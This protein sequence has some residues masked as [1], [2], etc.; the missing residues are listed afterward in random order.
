MHH[1]YLLFRI[2]AR[3]NLIYLINI[4]NQV[5]LVR[6]QFVYRNGLGLGDQFCF[7]L[8]RLIFRLHRRRRRLLGYRLQGAR[9][10][11]QRLERCE[12]LL[13]EIV[14]DEVENFI[15]PQVHVFADEMLLSGSMWR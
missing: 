3:D 1:K 11:G 10:L 6:Q 8:D 12:R 7:D 9:F 14:F 15:R 5:F 2:L 13:R 4:P